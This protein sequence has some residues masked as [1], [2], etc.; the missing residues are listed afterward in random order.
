[1]PEVQAET[2]LGDRGQKFAARKTTSLCKEDYEP[3]RGRLRAF[4]TT[5]YHA[6]ARGVGL[7]A[8]GL[9]GM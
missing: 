9:S 4:I 7:Y 5:T 3:L 6:H 8:N 2:G 1:M